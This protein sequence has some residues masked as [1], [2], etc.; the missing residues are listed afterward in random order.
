MHEN[1]GKNVAAASLPNFLLRHK[2]TKLTVGT[3]FDSITSLQCF[4]FAEIRI[5]LCG[6]VINPCRPLVKVD[7][8]T[9][10]HGCIGCLAA[11]Q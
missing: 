2:E 4:R 9:T 10:I 1:L 8:P 5:Y 11:V 6:S 3:D 7:R